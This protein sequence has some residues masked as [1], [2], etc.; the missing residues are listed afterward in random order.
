MLQQILPI[1]DICCMSTLNVAF[2]LAI[3]VFELGMRLPGEHCIDVF[4]HC[5]IDAMV[6]I[7]ALFASL[8]LLL[9]SEAVSERQ[10]LAHGQ[11]RCHHGVMPIKLV[12]T[13]YH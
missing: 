10:Q 1:L 5:M 9:D 2:D 8:L 4:G 13:H 12:V 7:A 3:Q 11:C 6:S